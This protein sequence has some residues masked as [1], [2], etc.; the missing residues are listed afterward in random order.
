M[1]F[2]TRSA[3]SDEGRP[4]KGPWM[5]RERED[6]PGMMVSLQP[7]DG[8]RQAAEKGYEGRQLEHAGEENVGYGG[9]NNQPGF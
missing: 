3:E 1:V 9:T 8:K 7:E 5:W 4:M 6:P 2:G